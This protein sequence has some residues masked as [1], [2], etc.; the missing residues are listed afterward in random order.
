[1]IR[2]HTASVCERCFASP[3][4]TSYWNGERR[5]RRRRRRWLI[6][7]LIEPVHWAI[8]RVLSSSFS[9]PPVSLGRCSRVC[10]EYELTIHLLTRTGPSQINSNTSQ[11]LIKV[12]EQTTKCGMINYNRITIPSTCFKLQFCQTLLKQVSS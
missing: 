8:T 2:S 10:R 9:L 11:T 12:W 6:D 1:M 7:F 3:R 5:S 4:S